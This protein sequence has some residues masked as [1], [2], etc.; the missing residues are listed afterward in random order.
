MPKPDRSV[1]TLSGVGVSYGSNR[2]FDDMNLRVDAGECLGVRGRNGSGKTTLL[3]LLAN[4]F[5]L[6]HGTREGPPLVA[7]VPA[8]LTPPPI[9]GRMWLHGLPRPGRG[10]PNAALSTL[11]F[12]GLLDKP[13]ASLSFGNLRKLLLAEAFSAGTDLVIVDEATAGLDAP[14]IEGVK[15][16]VAAALRRGAAVVMADQD[17]RAMPWVTRAVEVLDGGVV[18]RGV[19]DGGVVDGGVVHGAVAENPEAAS[20]GQGQHVQV[21]LVG[22]GANLSLL[23]ETASELG[24]AAPLTPGAEEHPQ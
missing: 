14:G 22:P 3:R 2:V 24:F 19:V 8:A 13:C 20:A 7:Y 21:T 23:M 10:D 5:A 12:R 16:L 1:V 9:T 17:K 18:E 4:A 15:Q 11:A 6:Q